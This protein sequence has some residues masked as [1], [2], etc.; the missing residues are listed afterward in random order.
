MRALWLK[1]KED[2]RHLRIRVPPMGREF[3]ANIPGGRPESSY[4]VERAGKGSM[5]GQGWAPS[6]IDLAFETGESYFSFQLAV[7]FCYHCQRPDAREVAR[8]SPN[9]PPPLARE[10]RLSLSHP[11]PRFSLSAP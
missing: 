4:I 3:E 8:R 9:D 1:A 2:T 10:T 6:R 7:S 11:A 5:K